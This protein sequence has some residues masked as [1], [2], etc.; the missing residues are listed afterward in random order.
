MFPATGF[1]RRRRSGAAHYILLCAVLGIPL[2][3]LLWFLLGR[4]SWES[5]HTRSGTVAAP[6]PVVTFDLRFPAEMVREAEGPP[7]EAI[8][9]PP[10]SPL[11]QGRPSTQNARGSDPTELRRIMDLGV[12]QF[13]AAPNDAGKSKGASLVQL[14]ALLGYPPARQLIIRN[15]PRSP[16]VQSSVPMQDVVRFAVNLLAQGAP[17][18]PSGEAAEMTI[19]LGNYFSRRGDVLKFSSHVVEAISD[20]PQLQT[21]EQIMR[22]FSVFPRI[23]G[24]CTGI[25]RAVSEDQRIDQDECSAALNDELLRYARSKAGVGI[26]AA[27]RARAMQLLETVRGTH[28]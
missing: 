22:L 18:P 15:Y 12:S 24:V 19:A 3:A 9:L 21:S 4:V 28:K 5:L 2:F 27:A 10:K 13:A 23:P 25:K 6:E 11:M 17:A 1:N 16:A 8:S 7:P 20:D 26:D 14:S